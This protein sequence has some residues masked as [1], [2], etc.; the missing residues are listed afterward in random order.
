MVDLLYVNI[1]SGSFVLHSML[2]E[3]LGTYQSVS[4]SNNRADSITEGMDRSLVQVFLHLVNTCD[5]I[6]PQNASQELLRV[7]PNQS[8][9][10]SVRML[11]TAEAISIWQFTLDLCVHGEKPFTHFS[12]PGH[13]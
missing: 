8:E 10:V 2:V 7:P 1:F 12:C 3:R 9:V 4:E 5:Q 11:A 6:D 13:R